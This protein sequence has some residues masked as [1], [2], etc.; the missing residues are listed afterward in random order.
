MA[1]LAGFQRLLC[2]SPA[3]R[4]KQSLRRGEELRLV[5]LRDLKEGKRQPDISIGALLLFPIVKKVLFGCG[6]DSAAEN[7]HCFE[8]PSPLLPHV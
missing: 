7:I 2:T 4:N 1:G 8:E 3:V 6:K 5:P